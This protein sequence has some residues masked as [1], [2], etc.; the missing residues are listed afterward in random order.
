MVTSE[1]K[2]KPGEQG[3]IGVEEGI[4]VSVGTTV[5]DTKKAGVMV[6]CRVGEATDKVAGIPVPA[7]E[8]ALKI[9]ASS[10][11]QMDTEIRKNLLVSISSFVFRSLIA[12]SE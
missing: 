9:T 12:D 8:Q 5:A 3:G 11:K 7:W 2:V 4:G 6:G 1:R 10:K